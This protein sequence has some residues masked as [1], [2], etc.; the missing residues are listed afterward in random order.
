VI[1]STETPSAKNTEREAQLRKHTG[2]TKPQLKQ[3]LSQQP[4][5]AEI[6]RF[7]VFLFDPLYTRYWT[8][9]KG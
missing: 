3:P 6:F 5:R 7:A 1:S 9:Q 2:A 4:Q 8:L